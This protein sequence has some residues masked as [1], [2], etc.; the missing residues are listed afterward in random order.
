MTGPVFR[1]A[2]RRALVMAGLAAL[3][4]VAG[5]ASTERMNATRGTGVKRTFR[6]GYE[7]VY[8]ACLKAA[9][10]RKLEV[11][12]QDR[13]SGRILLS[14]GAGVTGPG[15]RIALFVTANAERS[16]TVEIASRPVV[17]GLPS[18]DWVSI[19]FGEIEQAL[20][21]SRPPR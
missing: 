5:C 20:A 4:A 8:D 15:E 16:S 7:T 21:K 6:Q 1:R 18:P 11:I 3:T 13:G 17:P 12:E 9:A 14:S 2:R 10:A 19:I